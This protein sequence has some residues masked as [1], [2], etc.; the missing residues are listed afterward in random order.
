ML[1]HPSSGCVIWLAFVQP[2]WPPAARRR[3]Y[4]PTAH[5]CALLCAQVYRTFCFV[6][7]AVDAVTRI[8]DY[9]EKSQGHAFNIGN[10]N[11]N[12]QIRQL[13]ALMIDLYSNLTGKPKGSTRDVSGVEYYGKG[14]EDS[15][16]RIPSMRLVKQQLDWSA[17][18]ASHLRPSGV[19]SLRRLSADLPVAPH[20]SCALTGSRRRR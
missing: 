8:I 6:E 14:Y 10:P 3:P 20:K 2:R 12:I 9:P 13:A 19:A 16:L 7:D 18:R 17:R 4:V 5:L 15:D 11:N 1:S